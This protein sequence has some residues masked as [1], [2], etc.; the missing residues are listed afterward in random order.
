MWAYDGVSWHE[1]ANQCGATDGRIAWAGADEFWTVSD[2]R[3]GQ[4]AAEGIPP[5]EDNTLCHFSGGQI[6]G[7]YASLA[8]LPSSY[9]AM[10]GAACLSP[11]D[12]WFGGEPLPNGR[13]GA[14]HLHWNGRSMTAEAGPQGHAVH[15][16]RRFGN[17][18]YE[19]VQIGPEDLLSEREPPTEPSLAHEIEPT[20]VLPT[21]NSLF[22]IDPLLPNE[23][24]LPIYSSGE[25]PQALDYPRLSAD[26]LALWAAIDPTPEP[27]ESALGEVT[28]LRFSGETWRQLL[29][30]NTDPDAENPFTKE[31][32]KSSKNELVQSIAAEPPTAEELEEETEHAW[33]ALASAEQEKAGNR[34]A[35]TVARLS[36]ASVVSRRETLPTS[37]EAAR[38][39]GPK[40]YAT[41][42]A[43]AATNDCW[44]ATSGGWLFHLAPET[45][46]QHPQDTDPAFAG[47]ISFRPEDQGVPQTLPDALPEDT[48]GLQ[49]APPPQVKFQ[50]EKAT[51]ESRITVPLLSHVRTKLLAGTTLELRFHLAAKARVRLLAERRRRVVA[52]TAVANVRA[53]IP[54]ARAASGP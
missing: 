15:S 11:E 8:F 4:N 29:G 33:L 28:I 5:L 53:R 47:L 41:K 46:R 40:G 31:H 27:S 2:G 16:I 32:G 50:E 9:Q 51:E 18:I 42:I 22:P 26:E 20:G 49:E 13:T 21:F 36:S 12:C 52:R 37:E 1:L 34:S 10:H 38:G 17:R 54:A 24:R 48:S 6:V 30:P 19:G 3:P 14:F 35:A 45:E 39:V 7:S 25:S 44:L 23:P 43:C